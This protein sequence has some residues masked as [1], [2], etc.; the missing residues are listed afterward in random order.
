M[1]S[2]FLRTEGDAPKAFVVGDRIAASF[3]P[4]MS[5]GFGPLLTS[6]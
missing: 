3:E 6:V 5:R 1:R 2:A 4:T